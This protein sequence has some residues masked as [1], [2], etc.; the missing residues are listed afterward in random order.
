MKGVQV[1]GPDPKKERVA[2]VSI[3]V[4]NIDPADLALRLDTE[5][6]IMARPGLHC[7]PLAHRS[8]GSFPSGSLRFSLSS[9]TTTEE[10]DHTIIAIESILKSKK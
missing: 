7:A 3:R 8:L 9:F 2:V 5:F 4:D 10:L 1:F 6:G